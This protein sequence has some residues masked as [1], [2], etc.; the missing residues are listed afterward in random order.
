MSKRSLEDK[1][2]KELDEKLKLINKKA[3]AAQ[4][5]QDAL[6]EKKRIVREVGMNQRISI[7]EQELESAQLVSNFIRQNLSEDDHTGASTPTPLSLHGKVT[8]SSFYDLPP[9]RIIT[10][11]PPNFPRGL[12]PPKP[13]PCLNQYSKT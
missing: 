10:L 9:S 1:E 6:R 13:F 8:T 7:K 5:M 2:N 4:H 12:A 11:A 3:R